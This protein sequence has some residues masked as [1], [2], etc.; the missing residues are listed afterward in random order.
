[1][2]NF[3]QEMEQKA[4]GK[5]KIIVFPEAEDPR[6]LCAAL[7]LHQKGVARPILLGDL[8]LVHRITAERRWD[9][10]GVAVID[11]R[12]PSALEALAPAYA[13]HSGLPEKAVRRLLA[14]PLYF[15]AALVRAGQADALVAGVRHTTGEVVMACQSVIGMREGIET[16]SSLFVMRIPGFNGPAG[17]HLIFADCGVC[18]DPT[19]EQLADIAVA[20]AQTAQNMMGWR[21]QVAMLSF[22]T[23]GSAP[24][25]MPERVIRATRL[26]QERLPGLCIDGE[27]QADAAILPEIAVK[28]APESPVAGKAN[29]LIFPDLNAG[30]IAYKLVQRLAKADAFGPILQG[31][32]KPAC[33]LSR[34]ATV[35]DIVGAAIL[36]AAAAD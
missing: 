18:P 7:R 17:E 24:H 16:P 25:S 22:S 34:G 10:S 36:T 12:D 1:M 3:M 20:T 8:P 35:D 29:I 28:K 14:Q 19:P 9:L 5:N 13:Q 21:P 31:F 32:A 30:N 2:R 26:A 11:I 15:A 27:L 4:A 23:K 6:I 33:D